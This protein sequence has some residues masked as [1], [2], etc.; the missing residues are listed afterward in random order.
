MIFPPPARAKS[1]TQP[2]PVISQSSIYLTLQRGITER[3]RTPWGTEAVKGET[4]A[5]IV[6][7]NDVTVN[8]SRLVSDKQNRSYFDFQNQSDT[9]MRVSFAVPATANTG[10]LVPAGSSRIWDAANTIGV[11]LDAVHVFCT[12]AGKSYSFGEAGK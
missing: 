8:G 4:S 5:N 7:R 6:V 10:Y 3:L 12:V 2:A 11:V 9:D 1:K